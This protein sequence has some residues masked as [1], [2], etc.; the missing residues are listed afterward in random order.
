MYDMTK[1]QRPI[2]IFYSSSSI[3]RKII[4]QHTQIT[5]QD[6]YWNHL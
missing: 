5:A 2:D 3:K 6:M 1:N 4:E